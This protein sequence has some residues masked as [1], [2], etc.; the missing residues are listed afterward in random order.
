[1][2]YS[3]DEQKNTANLRKHGFDF[4]DA[5]A[6]FERPVLIRADRRR[7]YGEDRY[8]AIGSLEG[9]IVTLIYTDREDGRR[10]I[11]V[12]Q[13]NRKERRAYAEAFGLE[14]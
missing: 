8:A 7:N 9:I 3:W 4:R 1:V 13:S 11:S 10:I 14:D 6:I 2:R 12:R 5:A